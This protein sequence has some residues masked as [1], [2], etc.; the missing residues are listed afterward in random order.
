MRD[1]GS[2]RAG[3]L[4]SKAAYRPPVR[5]QPSTPEVLDL[6]NPDEPDEETYLVN[7]NKSNND[8]TERNDR[9]VKDEH[10]VLGNAFAPGEVISILD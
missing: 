8:N 5:E 4:T 2:N 1:S 3:F 6:E 10:T 9:D 7:N